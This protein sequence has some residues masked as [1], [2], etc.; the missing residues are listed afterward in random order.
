EAT[1]GQRVAALNALA[2]LD[3]KRHT[4]LLGRVLADAGQPHGV[5]E[6]SAHLLARINL[7][8]SR[9][10][11]VKGLEAA[12]AP[13]Q[14][15]IATDLAGNH[16]GAEQLLEAVAA[17]KASARLLQERAVDVRLQQLGIARLK[18]RLAKLTAGL[19]PADQRL[20]D[21]LRRR[22]EGFLA[23]K[24]DVEL[25]QKVFEKNCAICHQLGGKGTQIGP[26]LDGIGL[27]GPGRL[28]EQT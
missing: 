15:T 26:Q 27:R 14:N 19:P 17:G 9:E 18:E 10:Q 5:R 13:L 4:P 23:T 25:G 12:P 22:R 1:E 16:E 21:L 8:G 7:P 11:L 6:H 3:G 20:E 28:L 2:S 24:K